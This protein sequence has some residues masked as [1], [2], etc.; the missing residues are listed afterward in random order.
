[1]RM[2]IYKAVKKSLDECLTRYQYDMIFMGVL[3]HIMYLFSL[4]LGFRQGILPACRE[5]VRRGSRTG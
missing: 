5:L 2:S 4:M 1:M 3:M